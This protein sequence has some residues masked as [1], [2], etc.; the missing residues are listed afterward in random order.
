VNGVDERGCS[1]VEMVL[2]QKEEFAKNLRKNK[3][4]SKENQ[5]RLKLKK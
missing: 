3:L 1:K 2:T 5:Q 4:E